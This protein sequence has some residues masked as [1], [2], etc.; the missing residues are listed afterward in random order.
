M[1]ECKYLSC[2]ISLQERLT[3][4]KGDAALLAEI[5]TVTENFVYN[6]LGGIFRAV[7]EGPRIG[8]MT[9]FATQVTALKKYNESDAGTVYRAQTLERVNPSHCAYMDS[10]KV[11]L[12]T[13]L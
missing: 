2:E 10:W 7:G 13:S 3:T 4:R 5:F 9:A 8:I 6:L 12:I 11:R 1:T